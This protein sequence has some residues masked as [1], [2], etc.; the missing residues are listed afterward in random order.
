LSGRFSVSPR[1]TSAVAADSN[2]GGVFGSTNE[3]VMVFS[4]FFC[5]AGIS[6]AS[7]NL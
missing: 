7:E 4:S 5:G 3:T 2:F 1:K 6:A